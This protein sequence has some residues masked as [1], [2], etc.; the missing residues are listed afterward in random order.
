MKTLTILAAGAALLPAWLNAGDLT[1]ERGSPLTV[2]A[3]ITYDKVYLHD[4]LTVDSHAVVTLADAPAQDTVSVADW[5]GED[6]TITLK[7]GARVFQKAGQGGY[8]K[9]GGS[10]ATGSGG[11][12]RLRIEGG[13]EGNYNDIFRM[14]YFIVDSGADVPKDGGDNTVLYLGTND[15]GRAHFWTKGVQNWNVDSIRV[16]FDGGMMHSTDGGSEF[17]FASSSGPK[18]TVIVE[19]INGRPI[20]FSNEGHVEKTLYNAQGKIVFVGDGDFITLPGSSIASDPTAYKYYMHM[21]GGAANYDWTGFNGNIVLQRG[22]LLV[23]GANLLPCHANCGIVRSTA[24]LSYVDIRY[25]NAVNGFD[26]VGVVTNSHVN[27]ALATVTVGQHKDGPVKAKHISSLV[28][29]KQVGD[30]TMTVSA[31]FVGRY[32][33]EGGTLAAKSDVTFGALSLAAGTT[34]RIDGCTVRVVPAGFVNEGADIVCVNGG[35]L[36]FEAAEDCGVYLDVLP[37]DEFAKTGKGTLV[38][39]QRA[40]FASGSVAVKEGTLRLAGLGSTNEWWRVSLM[41]AV[42][43]WYPFLSCTGLFV[44]GGHVPVTENGAYI[45]V[46][47]EDTTGLQRGQAAFVEHTESVDGSIRYETPSGQSVPG[48][49]A[50]TY[51]K[52]VTY[53]LK[54]RADQ[55]CCFA[56]HKRGAWGGLEVKYPAVVTFRR[57]AG[58][59]APVTGFSIRT[60]WNSN[61]AAHTNRYF[62]AWKVETSADG[63]NWTVAQDHSAQEV[64]LGQYGTDPWGRW[65]GGNGVTEEVTDK[66]SADFE[67]CLAPLPLD[68][69]AGCPVPGAKGM[70]AAVGVR[71]DAGATFDGSLVEG[72]RELADLTV[73]LATGGGTLKGVRL[74]EAGTLRLVNAPA[75]FRKAGFTVPLAFVDSVTEGDLSGWKVLVDGEPIPN[76]LCWDGGKLTVAPMG[77]TF[78]V[79]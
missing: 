55:A 35:R 2:S 4:D 77:M 8:L 47:A 40:A 16:Q 62:S 21:Q 10:G 72:G 51:Y 75:G 13:K 22:R 45:C 69:P 61:N 15:L 50:T 68:I 25:D 58:D 17:W 73:D 48:N 6:V 65:H 78:L 12:G 54:S 59:D 44:E 38:V 32:R 20:E 27:G 24:A 43:G 18:G 67:K 39:N 64:S 63:V 26:C 49:P 11:F 23:N 66:T 34:L 31:P 28:L 37:V 19:S 5:P 33:L 41:R 30:H 14:R 74:A 9:I 60:P 3:D 70:A 71:V 56:A 57:A 52:D 42:G 29:L 7:E 46:S 53:L 36:V 79:K 76:G 1:V